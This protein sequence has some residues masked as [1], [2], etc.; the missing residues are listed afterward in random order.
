MPTSKEVEW[1]SSLIGINAVSVGL[2][3]L[4]E[5]PVLGISHLLLVQGQGPGVVS[6]PR[7]GAVL[8]RV[9]EQM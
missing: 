1:A 7:D 2:L 3:L 5:V 4:E 8:L 6:C 9:E